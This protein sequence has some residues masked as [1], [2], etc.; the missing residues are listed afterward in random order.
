MVILDDIKNLVLYK[1]DFFLPLEGKDKKHNSAIILFTPNYESSIRNMQLPYTIN[2]K[3]FESY[4]LEKDVTRY[5]TTE[6]YMV[7]NTDEL[8]IESKLESSERN[9]LPDD[10][11]GIPSERKYPLHDKKHVLLAI[12]FFNYVEDKY[13][14]EL[15]SN[16]ISKIKE[17]NMKEDVHVGENNR[18]Y[19]YWKSEFPDGEKDRHISESMSYLDYISLCEYFKETIYNYLEE[20][21]VEVVEEVYKEID[22]EIIVGVIIDSNGRLLI[23]YHNKTGSLAFP[24]GKIENNEDHITALKRELKEELDIEVKEYKYLF[25]ITFKGKSDNVLHANIYFVSK[26]T[27]DIKNNEPEKHRFLK[28]YYPAELALNK[29]K[30]EISPIVHKFLKV[31]GNDNIGNTMKYIMSKQVLSNKMIYTGY[32]SDLKD[33]Y[34]VVNYANIKYIFG[35]FKVPL[36]DSKKILVVCT[37][38]PDADM[39]IDSET[40]T[41]F[42]KKALET[43]YPG[44]EK[45]DYYTYLN[46]VC[47]IY[48]HICLNNMVNDKLLYAASRYRLAK[49]LKV[50]VPPAGFGFDKIEEVIAYIDE[51]GGDRE[52]N[53]IIEKND[54][55]L[56]K[57]YA[58]EYVYKQY[59]DSNY[60]TAFNSNNKI[61]I[62]KDIAYIQRELEDG[63]SEFSIIKEDTNEGFSTKDIDISKMGQKITRKIKNAGVY[64]LNKIKRDITKGNVGKETRGKST[65]LE[66]LNKGEDIL[67]NLQDIGKA[68]APST[69]E[70]NVKEFKLYADPESYI[71]FND[72]TMMLTELNA[73][74]SKIKQAIYN[75]RLK[76]IKDV[77]TIYRK[78][79][80]DAPFI[81]FTFPDPKRYANRNV[82]F[83]ISYYLSSYIKNAE[84]ED[85]DG[86][87]SILNMKIYYTLIQRLLNTEAFK[88]Y[89]KKTIFLP[90]L[91]WNYSKGRL[92][93]FKES[94]NPISIIYYFLKNEPNKLKSLFGNMDVVFLG[95]RNYFKINFSKVNFSRDR[96]DNAFLLLIKR[97]I[98]LGYNSPADPDPEDEPTNSTRGIAMDIISRIE[99]SQGVEINNVDDIM[100]IVSKNNAAENIEDT[101]DKISFKTPETL[102]TSNIS[103]SKDIKD[104]VIKTDK[105]ADNLMKKANNIPSREDNKNKLVKMVIDISKA[106]STT[107]EAIEKLDN[108]NDSEEFKEL[109]NQIANDEGNK[110]NTDKAR[111]SRMLQLEDE[112]K[113]KEIDGKSVKDL[114]NANP[115]DIKIPKT[116]LNVASISD[117]WKN[118]TFMNFD[119]LYDPDSDIVKMLDSMK[120]WSY[121]I[122]IRDIKVED[123]S[124]PEDLLN[125][126]DIQCEDYKG[127]RF[128]LKI[129]IPKFIND[130]F[131]LLRGNE[132]ALMIQSTP[133]P[134]FKSDDDKCQIVG[135]G[136]YN[137]L[138][139]YR[140][141]T[142]GKSVN[143]VDRII[144]SM[145][146]YD[147]KDIVVEK[148]DNTSVS[149]KYELPIDYIDL[150]AYYNKIN[151]P[152]LTIFFNQ[153]ELKEKY[154]NIDYTKGI[155]VG[156]AKRDTSQFNLKKNDIIY[157]NTSEMMISAFIADLIIGTSGLKETYD[158]IITTS[159][160]YMYSRVGIFNTMIPL[161]A[162]C[163][164]LEGLTTTLNKAKIKYEFVEK[165]DRST[166][167]SVSMDYIKFMDG[168][169]MY[170]VT[171]QSS[172]LLNGLKIHDTESYSL[173]QINNKS[174]YVDLFD[175]VGNGLLTADAILNSYDCM[176]D[177]I[178][179]E[180]LDLW[181]LPTDYVKLLLHANML[182]A[183]NKFIKHTDMSS[184]RFRRKEVIAGYFYKALSDSYQTYAN[185]I[186]HS[187]K[188]S[189]MTVKQSAVIDM[190][191]SKDPSVNDLSINN[192][193]SE[194]SSANT[195][196]T[197]GLVGMNVARAYSMDTRVYDPSM[198][199]VMGMSTSFSGT[200][201]VNREATINASIEGSRGFIKSIEG[202]TSKLDTAQSL[203]MSEA[204]TPMGSTHDDPFRALMNH[205]QTAKH[206]VRTTVGDPQL[207]TNGA[208]EAV[209]Y[210]SSD[211]FA[212]KAKKNGV[213]KELVVNENS[214]ESYM[215]I[216][217]SDKTYDFIDLS[218]AIKKNSDGGYE[219][220]LKLSTDL[221]VGDKVKANDVVAYDK[222]SFSNKIGES[223]N[224]ALNVGT[225]AK[226]A[227]LNTD[228]GFEDS[229]AI[230]EGFARKLGTEVIISE[231]VIL[232]KTD[233]IIL[234][235]T[236]GSTLNQ[237]DVIL[238]YQNTYDDD[239]ANTLLKNLSISQDQL[240]DLGRK[241]VKSK[242]AGTLVG[243]EIICTAKHDELSESLR[244][245]VNSYNRVAN[246]K[247]NLYKK[248]NLNYK[249]IKSADTVENTGKAKNVYD[250]VKIIFKIKYVD[251]M[252][253]GDKVVFYS[254]NKG[255]IKYIIPKGEEPYSEFRKNEDIDA[256][257]SIGSLN[258]RMVASTQIIC[259]L[260]KLMVELDRS[261]KDIANIEYN[262]GYI[263]NT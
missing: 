119:K 200:V 195:V 156:V 205:T 192:V 115:N 91:D 55:N 228:E 151:T 60:Y 93:M 178:T 235:K 254:A 138:F 62:D 139:V 58:I 105:I 248:Y 108:S 4:Y 141:G 18:F 84:V 111:N 226:I 49:K 47:I 9:N 41:L 164:F 212:F 17:F 56:F 69:P 261:C 215:V 225:L 38:N 65:D 67:S 130:K 211:I 202:D 22:K 233:N 70:S 122:H 262:D 8:L 128:K 16:I 217:Y 36:I 154:P 190:I 114:L 174:M 181:K 102:F 113:K 189:K 188:D 234:H 157:F 94:L 169:L 176:L 222:Q 68:P 148:G 158:N 239:A 198:M 100:K 131:L 175:T 23:Q 150:S 230:T 5:I 161:V 184:R 135:V 44:V 231:E 12:K 136:G 201:G 117:D 99:K 172:M 7:P 43:K 162:I 207:V 28:W 89:K 224:L 193:I 27:G 33:I 204:L 53:K 45:I 80:S 79:R 237:G 48:M 31:Y 140:F 258:G 144:K 210:L 179:L 92:W 118:M 251:N 59:Q 232:N 86:R 134:I 253:I 39:Y 52:I 213:V 106:S 263:K 252:S 11:F 209:A 51:K 142:N 187:R 146:K 143:I 57:K 6:G 73:V 81:R 30:M 75:D 1:K 238:Q 219:V 171:Y 133:I 2:R 14:E 19:E 129:D 29:S 101:S 121:P 25:D 127:S 132:K 260:S 110:V 216:E 159:V 214:R 77:I 152:S 124:T 85:K 167:K 208:D 126:W 256:F 155:P 20:D 137:K 236:I 170:E 66:K 107:D 74:D 229:A 153:D 32:K 199:N 35:V 112:F 149:S 15:A 245:L 246:N 241:P 103:S 247:R 82:F 206:M 125:L 168:Y 37:S 42:S 220:P 71:L 240:S 116:S 194:V 104:E 78:V 243:V 185:M 255:V 54:L 61:N 40:I 87:Q 83:D 97:I 197:K 182:L 242:Y 46:Y 163:G 259:A 21:N 10:M 160:K 227:I 95:A 50:T 63:G 123:N 218:E 120:N 180:I 26:Y 147:G 186:R 90:I 177:P 109:L 203:T 24:A 13:E 250:G 3:Y 98:K 88:S 173:A 96:V 196:T 76:T 183:D 145:N 257:I 249:T 72:H 221:K 34:D 191:L 244:K 166:K 64:K 165:M 223:G